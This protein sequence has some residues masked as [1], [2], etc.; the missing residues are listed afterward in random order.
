MAGEGGARAGG[1]VVCAGAQDQI[2]IEPQRGGGGIGVGE[3]A[4]DGVLDGVILGLERGVCGG[5]SDADGGGE[6]LFELRDA[7]VG[8]DEGLGL[9]L[10]GAHLEEEGEERGVDGEEEDR[11]EED[12]AVGRGARRSSGG[13]RGWGLGGRG[14][15]R[16]RGIGRCA[17]VLELGVGYERW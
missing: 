3:G 5:G 7:G 1:R 15:H 12:P 13:G 9:C 2:V 14:R 8:G 6:L 16:V 17:V 4:G 10:H 11:R